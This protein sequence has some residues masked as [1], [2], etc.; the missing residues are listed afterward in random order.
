VT[1]AICLWFFTAKNLGDYLKI[2]WLYEW[3]AMKK[4]IKIIFYK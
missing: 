2:N 1:S 4:M 3:Q